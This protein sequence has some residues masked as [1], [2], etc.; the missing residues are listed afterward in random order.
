VFHKLLGDCGLDRL[1]KTAKIH[2][3][4]LSGKFQTCEECAIPKSRQNNINKKWKGGNQF[5]GKRL[6][7]DISSVRDASNRGSKFRALI[8]N[9]YTEFFWSIF[10]KNKSEMKDKIFTLLSNLSIA[11]IDVKYIRC[12]NSG[13]NKSFQNACC[14]KGYKIKFEFSGARMA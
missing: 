8:V 13:E 4:K 6:Y 3:F 5:P 2:D 12:N 1:E 14:E 11:R 10:L 7:L 9:N